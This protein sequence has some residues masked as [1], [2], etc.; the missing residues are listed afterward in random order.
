M[1][2]NGKV[3][4]STPVPKPL[5]WSWMGQL[6]YLFVE[7]WDPL[8]ILKTVEARNFKFG[9]QIDDEEF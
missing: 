8:H 7:F 6:R 3:G 4:N 2:I 9:M 1:K 5:N